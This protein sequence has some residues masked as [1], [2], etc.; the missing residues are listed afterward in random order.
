MIS[1]RS[2]TKS[3]LFVAVIGLLFSTTTVNAQRVAKHKK[4]VHKTHTPHKTKVV[5]HTILKTPNGKVVHNRTI[6]TRVTAP[7]MGYKTVVVGKKKYHHHNGIF[8]VKSGNQYLTSVAP[9]GANI[10]TLPLG[11]KKVVVGG[12]NYFYHHGAF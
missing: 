5:K 6:G 9:I 3:I 4:V 8:Y 12:A 11:Y 1:I 7:P 10:V 2:F